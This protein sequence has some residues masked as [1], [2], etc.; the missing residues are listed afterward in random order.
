M[1]QRQT[2][3]HAQRA[4]LQTIGV[5]FSVET[6][7]LECA[8]EPE[9][10]LDSLEL[11]IDSDGGCTPAS[12]RRQLDVSEKIIQLRA[13]WTRLD[14]DP[15]YRIVQLAI[16]GLSFG[17][18]LHALVLSL[19]Q[20]DLANLQFDLASLLIGLLLTWIAFYLGTFAWGEIVRA[21]HPELPYLRTIEY[22]LLSVVPKYLPGVGWQQVSK[23]IQL[24]RGGVPASQTVL[25]V[26]LEVGLII[27]T[28]LATALQVLSLTQQAILGLSHTLQL[29]TALLLWMV[30]MLLPFIVL[31]LINRGITERVSDR[32]LVFHLYLAE[33]LDAIGWLTLGLAFWFIIRALDP[34]PLDVLPYCITTLALSVIAGLAVIIVPNGFGIRELTMATLLQTILPVPSSI[35]VALV[36]RVVLVTAEFLGVLPVVLIDFWRW[37]SRGKTDH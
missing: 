11:L 22:H 36:S 18:M 35:I 24:Y 29:A 10:N 9:S 7:K 1:R 6:L 23:A 8:L 2:T 27:L 28:G 20:I 30:C 31:K 17:F 12:V 33:L 32:G 14:V 37:R 4:K 25:P 26:A 19:S 15:W 5:E 21:L 34:L 3:Y 16:V 13:A